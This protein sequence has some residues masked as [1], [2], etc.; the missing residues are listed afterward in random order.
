M[1]TDATPH[2]VAA[3]IPS[4]KKSFAQAFQV[5]EEINR[6]EAIALLLGLQWAS[7]EFTDCNF[8]V[9]CDN[10]EVVATL[11]KGTGALWR[12]H[13]LRRL[14]LSTLRGNT[15]SI[16]QVSSAA[17]LADRPSRAVLM[18]LQIHQRSTRVKNRTLPWTFQQDGSNFK[19][20]LYTLCVTN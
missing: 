3:I 9:N 20:L 11:S 4:L 5:P 18:T 19:T 8:T 1:Y 2:S 15:F 12:F 10:S 7:A 13:D 16:V 6:P 14:N 17:N